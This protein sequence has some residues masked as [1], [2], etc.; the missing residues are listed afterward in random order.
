M[1]RDRLT[2]ILNCLSAMSRDIKA[3]RAEVN[4]RFDSLETGMEN[5]ENPRG[6]Y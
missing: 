2:E 3:F 4:S 6:Q 1:S 5:L